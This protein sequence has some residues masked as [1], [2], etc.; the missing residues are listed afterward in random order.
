[1]SPKLT[2]LIEQ[3]AALS[4]QERLELATHLKSSQNSPDRWDLSEA[5]IAKRNVEM[6]QVLAAQAK[7]LEALG[8]E[9][10]IVTTNIGHLSQFVT[11]K[12]WQDC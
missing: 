3:S 8:Y 12:L 7:Q 11:A 4:A 5:S 1:M 10:I 2:Q 9:I 6:R